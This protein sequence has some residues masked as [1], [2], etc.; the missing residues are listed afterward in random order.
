MVPIRC[1]TGILESR[2]EKSPAARVAL[3]EHVPVGE[4]HVQKTGLTVAT[5]ITRK[6]IPR[7][8]MF[9]VGIQ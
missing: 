6:D 2:A 1:T 3:E 9:T 8:E 4:I 7:L 5:A